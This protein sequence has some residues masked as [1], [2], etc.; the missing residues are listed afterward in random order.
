MRGVGHGQEPDR[1]NFVGLGTNLAFYS[2][3]GEVLDGRMREHH[4]VLRLLLGF[5]V[6]KEYSVEQ[7]EEQGDLLGGFG[8]G[9]GGLGECGSS[10]NGNK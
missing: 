3:K 10:R 6:E 5:W 9:P 4:A 2:K 7:E 8:G 1:K